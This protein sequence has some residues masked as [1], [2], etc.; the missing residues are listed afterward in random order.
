MM[1]L[2]D[3][4]VDCPHE[5]MRIAASGMLREVLMG[6]LID[7]SCLYK[8]VPALVELIQKYEWA[9]GLYFRFASVTG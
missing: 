9:G 4:L 7:V 3:L 1:I 8:C 6:K 2:K 5:A